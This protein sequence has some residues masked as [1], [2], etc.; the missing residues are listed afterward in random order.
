MHL[1]RVNIMMQLFILLFIEF[2]LKSLAL[3]P[4]PGCNKEPPVNP[5]EVRG[6]EFFYMDKGLG[7]LWRNYIVQVPPCKYSLIERI[8][9]LRE[10]R[11]NPEKPQKFISNSI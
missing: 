2:A 11:Y 6:F 10:S 3:T 4:S 8:Q 9:L 1:A 5:D 7:S